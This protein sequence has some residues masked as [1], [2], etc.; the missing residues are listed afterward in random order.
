MLETAELGLE[1]VHFFALL[2]HHGARGLFGDREE[3]L[4]VEVEVLVEVGVPL[5]LGDV[6]A[7]DGVRLNCVMLLAQSLGVRHFDIYLRLITKLNKLSK[8][9]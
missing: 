6:L 1:Q 9:N 2:V 8:L 5:L 4:R 3:V 7:E